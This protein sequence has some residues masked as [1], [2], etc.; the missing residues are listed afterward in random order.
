MVSH[1]TSLDI[2]VDATCDK[3]SEMTT[4]FVVAIS[5][6]AVKLL[7]STGWM[8]WARTTAIIAA[9]VVVHFV[10]KTFVW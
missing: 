3:E 2:L 10:F 6:I 1:M 8:T 4:L 5:T 7:D 9:I